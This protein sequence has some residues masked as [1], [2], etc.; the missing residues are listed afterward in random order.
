MIRVIKRCCQKIAESS[1]EVIFVHL[2]RNLFS[3]RGW[4][5]YM[6]RELDNYR[7]TRRRFR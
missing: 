2:F 4:L 5:Y 6:H 7:E 1:V 3:H